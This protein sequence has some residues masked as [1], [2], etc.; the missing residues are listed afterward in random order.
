MSSTDAHRGSRLSPS[1]ALMLRQNPNVS[2]ALPLYPERFRRSQIPELSDA[3]LRRYMASNLIERVGTHYYREDG[4]TR[5]EAIHRL[6]KHASEYIEAE[7]GERE[8]FPCGHGGVRNVS[9]GYT[10]TVDS[11][12]KVFSRELAEQVIGNTGGGDS[13]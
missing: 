2:R 13:E 1:V 4:T 12:D 9:G 10:C 6:T 3:M 5:T 8:T 11:C 7:L